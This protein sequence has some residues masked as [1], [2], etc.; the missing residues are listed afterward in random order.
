MNESIS[1]IR[2]LNRNEIDMVR[3]DQCVQ[4]SANSLIYAR[5]YYLDSMAKHWSALIW[6]DYEA[7]M[8]LPWNRKWGL[9]Y[10]YQPAF[11]AQ[12]GLF[13]RDRTD[14]TLVEKFIMQAKNHFR[15]CEIHLNFANELPGSLPRN[16]Y[17]LDLG[18]S[19]AEIRKSYKKRLIENLEEAKTHQLQYLPFTD[20]FSAIQLF[21]KQYGARMPQVRQTDFHHFEKLCLTLQQRDMIFGRQVRDES[22]ELLN[23]S[24]FF[25]DEHRIYN[26]MSTSL[27]AGRE[28]RAHFHLLDQL[29]AEFATHQMLLDFEGSEIEGVA[30][31]YR[32]FGTTSQP[33]PFV[34]YNLLPLPF[35]LFK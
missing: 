15:F 22:G 30:E 1:Q 9:T 34:R 32:K 8:P 28:K 2:F 10:L 14:Q 18:K 19:Y 20:F 24:I 26:I 21:K 33:Y 31:F 16:N 29:I 25:R 7:V 11:T 5:T 27:P 23:S 3:W 13:F 17:V 4:Q 35:R 12:L 6:K